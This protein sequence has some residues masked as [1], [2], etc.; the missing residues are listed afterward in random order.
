MG[1]KITP[2]RCNPMAKKK[3]PPTKKVQETPSILEQLQI[4]K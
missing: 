3:K 2:D 1:E 4:K